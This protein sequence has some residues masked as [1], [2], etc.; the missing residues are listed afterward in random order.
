MP[1]QSDRP[2]YTNKRTL[3]SGVISYYFNPPSWSREDGCPVEHEALGTDKVEAYKR[4]LNVLLPTFRAWQYGDDQLGGRGPVVGTFE[5]MLSKVYA[6]HRDFTGLKDSTKAVERRRMR[7]VCELRM[8]D[9]SRLGD[10]PLK[11]FEPEIADRIYGVLLARH[12]V[13]MV[14]K[15]NGKMEEVQPGLTDANHIIKVCHKAWASAAR[16]RSSQVPSANPFKVKLRWKHKP[17]YKPTW[18][19]LCA[20]V[21]AADKMGHYDIA[22]AAIVVWELHQRPVSVFGELLLSHYRPDEHPNSIRIY[23]G[24]TE[25]EMWFSLFDSA[26]RGAD[27]QY[28]ELAPRLEE[29]AHRA[30]QQGRKDGLML[31]N[32]DAK[33]FKYRGWLGKEDSLSRVNSIVRAIVKVAG[34]NKKITLEAFRHGGITGMADADMTDAQMRVFTRHPG[35]RL[36]T[37]IGPT[38]A[39]VREGRRKI[40]THRTAKEQEVTER[41]PIQMAVYPEPSRSAN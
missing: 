29:L 11:E 4:V 15:P 6:D 2:Q 22:T 24:K 1:L 32:Y 13:V 33:A 38:Q 31:A 3:M 26:T 20:F 37:Y 8:T 12:P 16:H 19:E 25:Q 30:K 27:L 39:Q 41:I 35:R 28:E 17:T 36:P 18:D 21:E 40:I 23:H 5:W 10:W 7:I 14:E 34:L 9:G